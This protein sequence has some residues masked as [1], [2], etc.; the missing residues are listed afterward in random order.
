MAPRYLAPLLLALLVI[1]PAAADSAVK[2]S[3]ADC[4]WLTRHRPAAD[5]AYR[6]GVDVRG[7]PVAPADLPD[8]NRVELPRQISIVLAV[9]LG[10]LLKGHGRPE[11]AASEVDVGLATVDRD[12]G[13]VYY[14]GQLLDGG[15]AARL[16]AACGDKLD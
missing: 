5:V 4:R 15:E 12:S 13:Q 9:P 8:A 6:P 10:T 2:V 3:E 11:L 14:E 7:R 16:V 1:A